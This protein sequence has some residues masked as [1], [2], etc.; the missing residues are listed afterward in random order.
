MKS[1]SE[2]AAYQNST[3]LRFVI[4]WRKLREINIFI[5]NT[6]SIRYLLICNQLPNK[7]R[8]SN[9]R[10]F[11]MAPDCPWFEA[12]RIFRNFS[13]FREK[14][15]DFFRFSQK[16]QNT[17]NV[18]HYMKPINYERT[19]CIYVILLMACV[20]QQQHKLQAS[21]FYVVCNNNVLVV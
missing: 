19:I 9:V 2:K 20:W 15:A 17:K 12:I 3:K 8:S 11:L 21:F 14:W 16:I 13:H 1:I 7:S 5:N 6:I 10:H 18:Q 4:F